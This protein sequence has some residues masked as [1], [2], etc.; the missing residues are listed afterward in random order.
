M[1]EDFKSRLIG[2]YVESEVDYWL[3]LKGEYKYLSLMQLLD[4]EDR[5]WHNIDDL[6]RYDKRLQIN[7]FRYFCMFEEYLRALIANQTRNIT[8]IDVNGLESIFDIIPKYNI[9]NGVN[10]GENLDQLVF[11]ELIQLVQMLKSKDDYNPPLEHLDDNLLAL[12]KMRNCICHNR[13][14]FLEPLLPCYVDNVKNASLEAN[15]KNFY[16]ILNNTHRK[17][18]VKIINDSKLNLNLK[19]RFIITLE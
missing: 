14:L 15:I 1:F 10:L 6:Y 16:Q 11:Y 4:A 2:K 19:N 18:F 13:L 8:I 12:K 9:K 3:K 17:N 7:I 5:T